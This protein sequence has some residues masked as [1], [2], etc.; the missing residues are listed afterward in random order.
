M[1]DRP[2]ILEVSHHHCMFKSQFSCHCHHVQLNFSW[3][4]CLTLLT[5]ISHFAEGLSAG[6]KLYLWANLWLWSSGF[7]EW[8]WHPVSPKSC[9]WHFVSTIHDTLLDGKGSGIWNGY[10]LPKQN[11]SSACRILAHTVL[12]SSKSGFAFVILQIILSSHTKYFNLLLLMQGLGPVLI[13]CSEDDDLAPCHVICGFA[14]RLVELGTDVK[15]IK[16]SDSPHTGT[17]LFYLQC[18]VLFHRTIDY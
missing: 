6:E 1:S 8:C 16:W 3:W 15:I 12:I 7:Y 17:T 11:W 5:Q 10:S 18:L 4:T 13:F 14:R 9:D 2:N